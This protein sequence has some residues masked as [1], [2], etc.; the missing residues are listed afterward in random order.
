MPE[1]VGDKVSKLLLD[2]IQYVDPCHCAY[3]RHGGCIDSAHQPLM[4]LLMCLCPEDVSS[5][6]TGP[7]TPYTYVHGW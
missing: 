2:E 6:R 7:L 5:I 1:D 3:A 4:L